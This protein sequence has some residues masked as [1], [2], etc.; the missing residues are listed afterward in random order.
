MSGSEHHVPAILQIRRIIFDRFNDPD[1]RFTNDEI[2]AIMRS[3][4]GVS[5][6]WD[7]ND[8]EDEFL[9]LTRC[10]LARNIAQN[11]TTI[12]FKIFDNM[13]ETECGACLSTVHMGKSEEERF[14]P[15]PTCKSP[16]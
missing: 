9:S 16:L 3:E 11:F 5:A 7:I 12:W 1:L 14:C 13:E 2:F 15:N 10:G 8:V 6:E 4:G